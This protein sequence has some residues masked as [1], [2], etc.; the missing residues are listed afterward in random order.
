MNS[1]RSHIPSGAAD[2]HYILA[3][4]TGPIDRAQSEADIVQRCWRFEGSSPVRARVEL[5]LRT[6]PDPP[7]AA[8]VFLPRDPSDAA[9][10]TLVTVAQR[11]AAEVTSL[12]VIDEGDTASGFLATI[13]QEYPDMSVQLIRIARTVDADNAAVSSAVAVAASA[14]VPG[15]LRSNSG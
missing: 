7:P 8:L 5:L 1:R 2:W 14:A 3:E 15:V 10:E 6:A 13:C 4:E 9:L 11:A 12:T